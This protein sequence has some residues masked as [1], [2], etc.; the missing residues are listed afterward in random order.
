MAKVHIIPCC[1]GLA[2]CVCSFSFLEP[3]LFKVCFSQHT[4]FLKCWDIET[5]ENILTSFHVSGRWHRQLLACHHKARWLFLQLLISLWSYIL[6]I[7]SLTT[8]ATVIEHIL[9]NGH[10]AGVSGLHFAVTLE[11]LSGVT[12]VYL[13]AMASFFLRCILLSSV[14]KEKINKMEKKW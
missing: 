5:G 3:N 12:K 6:I 2:F 4:I 13:T 9:C 10:C 11:H 7:R 14:N 8:I 1:H